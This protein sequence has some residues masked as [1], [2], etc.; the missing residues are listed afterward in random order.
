MAAGAAHSAAELGTASPAGSAGVV[1]IA[2]ALPLAAGL[3]A[4]GNHDAI[5]ECISALANIRGTTAA[6]ATGRAVACRNPTV[7]AAVEAASAREFSLPLAAFTADE[8]GQSLAQRHGN[9][10]RYLTAEAAGSGPLRRR[11]RH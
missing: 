9:R 1:A 11:R 2:V 7:T 5:T 3:A 4:T 8:D 10:S 6:V